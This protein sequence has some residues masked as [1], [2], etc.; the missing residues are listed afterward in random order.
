MLFNPLDI[1]FEKYSLHMV[2]FLV[3]TLP[4]KADRWNEY[5]S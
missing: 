1:N 4:L 3:W 2:Y 5:K